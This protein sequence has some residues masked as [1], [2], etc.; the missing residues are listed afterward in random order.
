[1][2]I[3]EKR[4]ASII[5]CRHNLESSF[6]YFFSNRRSYCHIFSHNGAPNS[7]KL[8]FI[9]RIQWNPFTQVQSL[10]EFHRFVSQKSSVP[11][12]MRYKQEFE[13]RILYCKTIFSSDERLGKLRQ[14]SLR[15]DQGVKA[16]KSKQTVKETC[17]KWRELFEHHHIP[18]AK[19]SVEYIVAFVL[20]KKTVTLNNLHT[21]FDIYI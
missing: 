13:R 20:G 5:L 1:M 2:A 16:R 17:E 6:T 19:A 18:E 10:T 7:C 3:L 15:S 12:G 21:F 14:L 8:K 11:L 9:T 4:F